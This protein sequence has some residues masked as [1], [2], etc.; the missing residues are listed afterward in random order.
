M[1]AA[2]GAQRHHGEGWML[3]AR[4]WEGVAAEYVKIRDV[5]GLAERIQHTLLGVRAHAGGAYFVDRS[6]EGPARSRGSGGGFRTPGG[7]GRTRGAGKARRSATSQ[8]SQDL[9]PR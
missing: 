1:V 5:V 3:V 2:A 8:P 7:V 6:A 4:G 9:A